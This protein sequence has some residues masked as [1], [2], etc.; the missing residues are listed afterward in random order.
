MPGMKLVLKPVDH[1]TFGAM[2]QPGKRTF[3][4]QARSPEQL[5]TLHI[6]KQ[7]VEMLAIS[8]EQFLQELGGKFPR[9]PEASWQYQ[10][11]EMQLEE[12]LEVSFEVGNMGLGYDETEDRLLLVAREVVEDEKQ[13]EEASV[14]QF[15]C[16]RDQLRK[17]GRWGHELAQRGRPICGN[18][19]QPIDP[20]GHFCPKRNG[21]KH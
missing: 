10:E 11:A 3:Y 12:P 15:W 13:A 17:L 19:G 9:L 20:A 8:V 18:C 2:G 4:L 14:A 6:E 7:Q 5:V 21:H 1:I 16:T